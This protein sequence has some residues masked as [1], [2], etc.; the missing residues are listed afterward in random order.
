MLIWCKLFQNYFCE[1]PKWEDSR[2]HKMLRFDYSCLQSSL[3]PISTALYLKGASS[4]RWTCFLWLGRDCRL[5]EWRTMAG[6]YP[7]AETGTEWLS[8][9]K[10]A[11]GKCR[12]YLGWT[13]KPGQ[14]TYSI[15][16]SDIWR[17]SNATPA[18][19]CS[20]K[21]SCPNREDHPRRAG[22]TQSFA[23]VNSPWDTLPW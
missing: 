19:L 5:C 14:S 10:K 20:R 6:Y 7:T 9:S 15:C 22:S 18:P 1:L 16:P 4:A 3:S 21:A 23:Q 8:R 17:L 11:T 12:Q 13:R 2:T